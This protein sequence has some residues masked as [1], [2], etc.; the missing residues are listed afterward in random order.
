MIIAGLVL[1]CLSILFSFGGIGI[2]FGCIG[3]PLII[4]KRKSDSSNIGLAGLILNIIG[5]SLSVLFF[6][7]YTIMGFELFKIFYN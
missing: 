1:G 7:I 3:L 4:V 5:L 6:I 2:I